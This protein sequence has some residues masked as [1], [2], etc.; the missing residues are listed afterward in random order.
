MSMP[1]WLEPTII[2]SVFR[3]EPSVPIVFVANDFDPIAFGYVKSL[4]QP[5]GNMTGVP[6]SNRVGGNN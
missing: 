4:A 2:E 5:S 3:G 6:A 1:A